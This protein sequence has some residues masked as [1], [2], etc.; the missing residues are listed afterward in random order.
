VTSIA[1]R[2]RSNLPL[3]A[4]ITAVFVWSF[5]PLFTRATS[6]SSLTF[7]F[8]RLWI[9]VP[10]MWGVALLRGGRPTMVLLRRALAPGL[11]FG[12]S[13]VL[14]FLAYKSTSIANAT[15]I[16]ALTPAL[17]L[18]VANRLFG[19]RRSPRQLALAVVAFVAVVVVV[20]GGGSDGS[21]TLVGDLYSVGNLTAWTIYF[22][23]AKTI[24]NDNVHSWSL[25]A[26]FFT[27][28]AFV[29]T[30]LAL[31][32]SD[33]LGAS[34]PSDFVWYVATALLPGLVGHGLMTWAQRDVDISVSSV[35]TLANAPLSMV[36][37]WVVFDESLHPIQVVG[38]ATVLAAL[39]LLALSQSPPRSD[40]LFDGDRGRELSQEPTGADSD[41]R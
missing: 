11:L 10:V 31:V 9:A 38:V 25:I 26:T 34:K 21:A 40:H 17:I 39:A 14:G 3:L 6:V 28:A 41:G 18:L 5:G 36:G 24:R 33:D 1:A 23:W 12:C 27:I 4:V 29:V 8:F 22:I 30:P 7:A 19:E 37:A 15:L 20:L 2:R 13:M 16:P 35:L 32:L